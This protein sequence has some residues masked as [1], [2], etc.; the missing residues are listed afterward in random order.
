MK[1]LFV[2][3][4]GVLRPYRYTQL[5]EQLWKENPTCKTRDDHGYYFA[6]YCMDALNYILAA[7][8]AY[9]VFS[10]DWRKN[11]LS[12]LKALWKDRGYLFS[13]RIIGITPIL[14]TAKRGDEI[15][16]WFRHVKKVDLNK[17][18]SY[19]ILDDHSDMGIEHLGRLI[20]TDIKYGLSLKNANDVVHVLETFKL[21]TTFETP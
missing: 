18:E 13:D 6:P 17:I 5:C 21:T 4:D 20:Q 9:I 10:T 11:G 15:T 16:Q 7:T 1:I 2:D 3:F 14:E 12:E 8:G 19:A